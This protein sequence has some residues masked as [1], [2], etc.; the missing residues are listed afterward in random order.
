MGVLPVVVFGSA[1]LDVATIDLTSIR[2]EG[3][4]PIR[5]NVGAR[6]LRLKFRAQEIVSVL[7]EVDD[8]DEVVLHLIGNL[9]EESGGGAIMAEDT[10]LILKKGKK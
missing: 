10:V 9:K 1:D 5:S 2:L 8:G 4:A 6:N 7:G 3:V